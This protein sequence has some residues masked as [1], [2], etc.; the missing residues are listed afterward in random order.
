MKRRRFGGSEWF[1]GPCAS[2]EPECLDGG[3]RAPDC[4]GVL[5]RDFNT[6][7]STAGDPSLFVGQLVRAQFYSRGPGAASPLNLSD[8]VEFC[9]EL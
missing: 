6:W 8:A 3:R 9:L 1:S 4:S 5:A 7:I 2:P